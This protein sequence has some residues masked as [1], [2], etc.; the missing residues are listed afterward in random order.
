MY[1]LRFAA[2]TGHLMKVLVRKW[3]IGEYVYSYAYMYRG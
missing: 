3:D 2:G 1:A